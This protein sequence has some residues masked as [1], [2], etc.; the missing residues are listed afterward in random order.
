MGDVVEVLVTAADS[1][2]IIS[3]GDLIVESITGAD[4]VVEII[5]PGPSG[6]PGIATANFV[7]DGGGSPILPGVKGSLVI[8]FG[9]TVSGWTLVADATGSIQIDIWKASYAAYPPT[10]ADSISPSNKALISAAVKA[11]S[12]DL[13]GWSPTINADDVLVFKVDSASAITRVTLG[14]SL[15]RT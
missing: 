2:E 1:V 5:V 9:C 10:V 12:T 4:S 13:T 11:S 14:L 6:T 7:I 3:G 8:P 15:T